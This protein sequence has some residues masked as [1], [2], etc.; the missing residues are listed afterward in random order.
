[1][2]LGLSSAASPNATLSALMQ[3]ALRHGLPVLELRAGDAHGFSTSPESAAET[4][5]ALVRELTA[6]GIGVVGYC[7]TGDTNAASLASLACTLG[8]ALFVD[9]DAALPERIRRAERVRAAGAEA[10]I[11]VRG[12]TVLDDARRAAREGLALVWE[13]DPRRTPVGEVARVLLAEYGASVRHVRLLGGGPES[14]MHEGR[15]IG[16]LMGRLALS[17]FA[18]SVILAPSS[19]RFHVVWSTWLG[20]RAGTGCGSKAPGAA[21][22]NLPVQ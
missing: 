11:V 14:V 22:N 5:P 15:G 10:A 16:E 3:G 18:G 21:L 17:G 2:Q 20:R 13:C 6:A 19:A 9:A 12:D 7:D 8:S 1:M 4:I